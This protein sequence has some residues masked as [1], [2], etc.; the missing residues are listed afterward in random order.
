VVLRQRDPAAQVMSGDDME[1]VAV[2]Y[3]DPQRLDNRPNMATYEQAVEFT[4]ERGK[5]YEVVTR[6]TLDTFIQA[7][8]SALPFERPA[9][10][11]AIRH[12]GLGVEATVGTSFGTETLPVGLRVVKGRKGA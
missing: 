7:D 2:A 1:P 8:G 10:E 11:A 12:G 4:V 9:F 6:G 5:L 3:G